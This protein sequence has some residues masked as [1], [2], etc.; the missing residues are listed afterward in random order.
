MTLSFVDRG[1]PF[2]PLEHTGP[3]IT[4]PLEQRD[5][6]GLGILSVKRATDTMRYDY[7]DGENRLV[8]TKS[9]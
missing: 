4:A 3:D 5:I 8:I 7:A 6:G 1:E 9:W 2:N